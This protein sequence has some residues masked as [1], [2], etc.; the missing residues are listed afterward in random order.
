ML[1][2]NGPPLMDE[3][4][5]PPTPI[6]GIRPGI[7]QTSDEEDHNRVK[8]EASDKKITVKIIMSTF[9]FLP[10]LCFTLYHFDKVDRPLPA[11][12][13]GGVE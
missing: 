7:K 3:S 13:G 5:V 4:P 11:S 9:T 2:L 1:S 6:F 8:E 10:S 12:V